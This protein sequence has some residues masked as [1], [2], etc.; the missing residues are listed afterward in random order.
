[1]TNKG[2]GNHGFT[3]N[4]D[5][6]SF[7][8]GSYIIEATVDGRTFSNIKNLHLWKSGCSKERSRF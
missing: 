8:D 6:P 3:L 5:W 7:G 1:M 4:V 2:N